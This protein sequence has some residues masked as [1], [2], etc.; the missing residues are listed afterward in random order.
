[1]NRIIGVAIIGFDGEMVSLP[2]PNRHPNVIHKMAMELGHPK[3]IKGDQGFIDNN[4]VFMSREEAF[5][6]AN[7]NGQILDKSKLRGKILF[8]EDLW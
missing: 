8:S 2:E 7:E 4:G 5:I 6:L 1:M 3:P